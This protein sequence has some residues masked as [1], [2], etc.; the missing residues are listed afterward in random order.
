VQ[1]KRQ[2]ARPFPSSVASVP[3]P[4]SL[5]VTALASSNVQATP[6][7]T[8]ARV[9]VSTLPVASV[10][11]GAALMPGVRTETWVDHHQGRVYL[12]QLVE[13]SNLDQATAADRRLSICSDDSATWPDGT[14]DDFVRLKAPTPPIVTAKAPAGEGWPLSYGRVFQLKE[15]T[16]FGPIPPRR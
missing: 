7:D 11:N 9:R 16:P 1:R 14:P 8:T 13:M 5:P 2:S 12:T 4:V 15:A 6:S 3:Q 10:A